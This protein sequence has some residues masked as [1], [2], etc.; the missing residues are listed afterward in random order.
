MFNAQRTRCLHIYRRFLGRV[1]H[2]D[3]VLIS[4]KH[5]L[6]VINVDKESYKL[7]VLY[8]HRSF[9]H[10]ENYELK[11]YKAKVKNNG[12]WNFVN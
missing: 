1:N 7:V 12:F 6:K 11:N 8:Y 3:E 9:E 4:R 2:P 5:D 10:I